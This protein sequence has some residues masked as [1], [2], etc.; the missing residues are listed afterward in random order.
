MGSQFEL[1]NE[2]T[3][4]AT[5]EQVWEAIATGPGVDSW[6]MG[7]TEI[8]PRVGGT[9][10][11]EMLGQVGESTITAF[12][13]GRHFAYTGTPGDD[14]G[15]MAF[16]YLIEGR[17]GGSTVLRHVHS[18]FLAGDDWE[19]EYDALTKGNPLYLRTLKHYLEFFADRTATPVIVFG[20]QQADE[21]T[22]WEGLKRGLSLTAEVR[23]GDAVRLTLPDGAQ[24]T[25]V[26][27]V[28]LRPSFLG[29]RSDDGLYRFVG[30][31]GMVL[32]GHHVFGDVDA[33]QAEDAWQTWLTNLYA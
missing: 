21:D 6:F 18:G 30:R 4:D 19:S 16:E 25:G 10:R 22:V 15:F 26:A 32:A 13:P 12:E 5:P 3:I 31:G 8:E 23:E 29:V 7:H 14:G 20:P 27:D 28:V 24:L 1:T 11:F 9:T 33:K 17:A 2:I